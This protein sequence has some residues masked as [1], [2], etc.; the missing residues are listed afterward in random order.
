MCIAITCFL[1]DD[2]INFE[3]NLGF[4]IKP[5][6]LMTKK[7]HDEISNIQYINVLLLFLY[8]VSVDF[9]TYVEFV[10]ENVVK[11]YLR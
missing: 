7:S 3:I 11:D 1:A 10:V 6:S 8:F 2:V 5:F 4:L 9:P